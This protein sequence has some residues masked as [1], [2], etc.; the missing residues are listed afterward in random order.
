MGRI[1][2]FS[3]VIMVL[4]P[5]FG[6]A[7]PVIEVDQDNEGRLSRPVM[8]S[9]N[10][11]KFF[12]TGYGEMHYSNIDNSN[13]SLDLHRFVLGLNY[14]FS[15][16]IKFRS[17]VEFEHGFS[18]QYIEF[19]YI[20]FQINRWVNIRM[21]SI[22]LP[23]GYL[24][25]MHE[26]PTYF[27]VERPDIYVSIIPTSWM[28]GGA[29]IYGKIIDGLTYELYAHTS[30]D[31]NNGFGSDTGFSGKSGLRGGRGKVANAA[32]NDF[33]G[34]AR[35]QYTGFKGVRLG[36]SSFV[37][38][39]AQGDARIPTGL[40]SLFEADAKFTF[41]GVELEGLVAVV[42]NPDAG[43]MTTAQRADGNISATDVIGERMFGFMIE[44]AYHVF[45]H[46]WD[47]APVDLVAFVRYE[48]IDTQNKTPTGFT[49][50]QAFNRQNVTFGMSFLP[51]PQ[52]AIKVDY[53]WR[54]NKAGT[55]NGQFN[56]GTAYYF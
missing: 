53:Q 42:F 26:P 50:N 11:R 16:R 5:G 40:V 24:N 2:I 38:L 41:E 10:N 14:D 47:N 1:F 33:A 20:D 37:G 19:A 4:A 52:V 21:G 45:H 6:W 25:V 13:D 34:S 8:Q 39:T 54:S 29:G 43:A 22:I 30:L 56:L 9:Q 31:F 15:D 7:A 17:E 48:K 23:I 49:K 27:S 28:E 36:V 55:A 32:A 3:F 44:G 51:I 12:I 35:L 46:V 18:E